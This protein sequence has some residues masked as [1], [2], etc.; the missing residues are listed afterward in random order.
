M[1][2]LD[3]DRFSRDDPI[4]EIALPLADVN[5]AEGKTMWKNLQPCKGHSGRLGE[6]L[7]SLCYQPAASSL[8]I[9]V[10][11][12][13]RISFIRNIILKRLVFIITFTSKKEINN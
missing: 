6:L 12:A 1:Q 11:K 4:G 10:I 2:V 3:Y 5:L 9:I 8:T 13:N 7:L